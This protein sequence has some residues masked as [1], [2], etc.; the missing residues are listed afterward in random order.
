M[1]CSFYKTLCYSSRGPVGPLHGFASPSS[2]GLFAFSLTMSAHL[3]R[4]ASQAAS[5]AASPAAPAAA[6]AAPAAAQ[7]APV[8]AAAAQAAPAAAAA[9]W[10]SSLVTAPPVAYLSSRSSVARIRP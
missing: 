10:I 9:V 4:A 6:A 5:Q 7:P 1:M 2:S 8:A 3:A